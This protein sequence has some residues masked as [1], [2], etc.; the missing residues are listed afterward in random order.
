[1]LP[2]IR[3]KTFT[4]N[5]YH[6][7]VEAGILGEDDHLELIRG[8]IIHKAAIGSCHA[9]CVDKLTQLFLT[10]LTGTVIFAPKES[11]IRISGLDDLKNKPLVSVNRGYSYGP[12][13]DNYQG[14]NK[15]YSRD[16]I[17]QVKKLAEQH[18]DVAVASEEPFKF[19]SKR[20][21][22]ADKF[23]VV[24]VLSEEPSYVAFSKAKGEKC[25]ILAE[26]FGRT[27]SRLKKEGVIQK[28]EDK[29]FK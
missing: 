7:M 5:E 22:F 25:K 4:A 13:F 19:F 6:R 9:A 3:R 16:E 11:S 10:N 29:Y 24:Y 20:L 26:K 8:E 28:I 21:G 15:D 1:M 17:M 18:T 14:L 2:Q 23:K 12:K 27:L